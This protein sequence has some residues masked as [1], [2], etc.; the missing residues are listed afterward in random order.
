MVLS[1]DLNADSLDVAPHI[2]LGSDWLDDFC[3][4]MDAIISSEPEACLNIL[5]RGPVQPTHPRPRFIV[6]FRTVTVQS[7]LRSWLV[8]Q[9][10][11]PTQKERILLATKC[12]VPLRY[13]TRWFSNER[14]RELRE[15]QRNNHIVAKKCIDSECTESRESLEPKKKRRF[16]G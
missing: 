10:N 13:V 14:Q 8:N 7:L 5:A 4:E 12:G 3:M 6:G 9:G 16:K 1:L 11:S 2:P 15:R